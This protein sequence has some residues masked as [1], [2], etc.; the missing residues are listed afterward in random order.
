MS[1]KTWTIKELLKVSTEYLKKKDIDSPRLSA[2][3]LLAHQLNTSRVELYLNFDQPLDDGEVAGY[4]QLIRRRADRE[5]IQ[6][7]TGRQEFWSLDFMVGPQVM[8]PR[9]ESEILVEQVISLCKEERLPENLSPSILDLGTGCGALAVALARE[10]EASSIWATDIS[11]EGLELAKSNAKKH[12]VQ[13]KIEFR[14]GDLWQPFMGQELKFDVIVSNPPYIAP[15]TID[16]LSSE[17]REYEP[18]L[19]FDGREEGMFFI[20]KIITEG[21]EFLKPGGWILVEMD[22]EQTSKALNLVEKSNNYEN[23]D[24]IKDYSQKYRVL[25]AQ[26]TPAAKP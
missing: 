9:P 16:S 21:P 23:K 4:R 19:A 12:G 1:A 24:R 26:S 3:I 6:Y 14:L 13:E 11:R 20:R 18:R 17:V 22:P 15:E 5:P 25:V 8:I 2:E 7:I 10:L